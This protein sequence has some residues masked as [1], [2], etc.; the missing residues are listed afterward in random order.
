MRQKSQ[1]GHRNDQDFVLLCLKLL[2]AYWRCPELEPYATREQPQHGVDI[3]DL[4]GQEPLR[5][6]QC[7]LHE[8]GKVTT[9]SEVTDEIEKAKGFKPP[10]DQ[11]VIMTTGKVKKEVHDLLIKVNREHRQNNLFV[12]QVFDWSR[13]EELLDEHTDIRDWYEGGPLAVAAG[14]IESKIDDLREVLDKSS[15][16]DIR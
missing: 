7:K 10:L 11:Y 14:R 3:V 6:A 9:R 2:R 12:V 15:G 1:T 8:E 16:P 4:S 13:I 5:A